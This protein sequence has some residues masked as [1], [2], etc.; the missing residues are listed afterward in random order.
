MCTVSSLYYK[1]E[2]YPLLNT[3]PILEEAQYNYSKGV[4]RYAVVTS[5]KRLSDEEIDKIGK[6]FR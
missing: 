6:F 5:G 2:T 3:K 1:I 4:A